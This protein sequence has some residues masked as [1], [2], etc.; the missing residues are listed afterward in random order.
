MSSNLLP[1]PMIYTT[2]QFTCP[3]KSPPSSPTISHHIHYFLVFI[4][5]QY[6]ISI[7]KSSRHRI[8]FRTDCI[9]SSIPFYFYNVFLIQIICQKFFRI[10]LQ[11]FHN[12][13]RTYNPYVFPEAKDPAEKLWTNINIYIDFTVPSTNFSD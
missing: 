6:F 8:N 13:P 4:Y 10:F 9:I 12:S 3:I 5:R 1:N 7:S 2:Y 11:F